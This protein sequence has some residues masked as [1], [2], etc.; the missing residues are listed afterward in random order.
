M[1]LEELV[2]NPNPLILSHTEI[3]RF[4]LSTGCPVGCSHCSRDPSANHIAFMDPQ[5]FLNS[6]EIL[7]TIKQR[8][9]LDLL[10]NYVVTD[11]DSEPFLGKNLVEFCRILLDK[12]GR[13]F[14]LLTSGLPFNDS[15]R[16]SADS[17]VDSPY[18]VHKVS[19]T[20]SHFS[21]LAETS[22][23]RYTETLT[24][25][26]HLLSPLMQHNKLVLSPQYNEEDE[27]GLHSMHKTL[28]TFGKIVRNAGLSERE[29]EGIVFP[30]PVIGLGRAST[31][32]NVKR[33]AKCRIEAESPSPS[34]SNREPER[35]YSG[36]ITIGGVLM[37][38][39][40]TRASLNAI[41]WKPAGAIFR[42]QNVLSEARV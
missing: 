27:G 3:D 18:L 35:P 10:A 16:K 29:L 40:S 12:T 37:V 39:K 22:L 20:I 15:F 31:K 30:R 7:N 38:C 34:I 21:R 1:N 17:I 25:V 4:Q 41:S 36:M 32:L 19:I 11:T 8:M 14:Y 26:V 33:Q 23:Q 5:N 6:L 13:Q 9:W 42:R 24:E 2:K 28:D